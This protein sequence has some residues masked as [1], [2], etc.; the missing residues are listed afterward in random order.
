[1]SEPSG[2]EVSLFKHRESVSFLLRMWQTQVKGKSQWQISLEDP[3]TRELKIFQ[4]FDALINYLTQI[5]NKKQA[6]NSKLPEGG[7]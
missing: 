4:N 5:M 3:S 6:G 1:M 2:D 7:F